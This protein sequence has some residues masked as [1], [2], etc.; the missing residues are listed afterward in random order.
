[1]EEKSSIICFGDSNTYGA[2][3]FG[4]YR[5][6][7][8]G[9]WPDILSEDPELSGKYE[10]V[11]MGENGREIPDSLFKIGSV[12][13]KMTDYEPIALIIIM[14]GTNDLI[15]LYRSGL[16]RVVSRMELFIRE[17]LE[18]KPD[19]AKILLVSPVHTSFEDYG[20]AGVDLDDLSYEFADA[21]RE[22]ADKYG[23]HFADAAQWNV[24][25]G[26]DGVHFSENGH[27]AFA[28]GIKPELMNILSFQDC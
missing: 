10:F 4:D 7:P 23:L 12:R 9:R 5:F 17:L 2:G 25:L 27:I 19:P 14:L 1:M 3:G 13:M 8:E 26:P 22:L 24:E 6:P 18:W 16:T 21:Y 15:K 11:N 28:Q 20:S